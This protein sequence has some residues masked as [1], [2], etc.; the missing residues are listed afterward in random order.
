MA[1]NDATSLNSEQPRPRCR[2]FSL[3]DAMILVVGVALV[4]AAGG[5]SLTALVTYSFRT[6]V[7]LVTNAPA[8][9]QRWPHF[10]VAVRDPLRQAVSLGLQF[11][12]ALIPSMTLIFVILRLRRPRPP[13]RALMF[14]PAW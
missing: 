14:S 2:R 5:H 4:L 8:I 9:G 1:A 12:S 7:A 6:S 3:L 10:P 13:W 11:G